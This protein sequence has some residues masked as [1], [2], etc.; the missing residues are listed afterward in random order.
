M[1]CLFSIDYTS[2]FLP[3]SI[4]L[5]FSNSSHVGVSNFILLS[6]MIHSI[7]I[8]TLFTLTVSLS[9]ILPTQT[10]DFIPPTRVAAVIGG[11][12]EIR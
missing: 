1:Q 8:S 4:S 11:S 3:T 2:V 6:R 10:P 7:L 5:D 9:F 12:V